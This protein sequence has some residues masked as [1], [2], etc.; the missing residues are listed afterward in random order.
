MKLLF[1]AIFLLSL[2]CCEAVVASQPQ[3]MIDTHA[4]SAKPL[5]LSWDASAL[6]WKQPNMT[7]EKNLPI[8]FDV[9]L[10]RGSAVF[11]FRAS[12]GSIQGE[13]PVLP[14][15]IRT[16]DSYLIDQSASIYNGPA[17]VTVPTHLIREST[18]A[19]VWWADSA[20][21]WT[22]LGRITPLRD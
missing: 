1:K 2:G 16:M 12:D 4:L 13:L 17:I 14:Q 19:E 11:V 22:R 5:G 6:K 18:S 21:E 8:D 3:I 7:G 15:Y 20:G 9:Q 10:P